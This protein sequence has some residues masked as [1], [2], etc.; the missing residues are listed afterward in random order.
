VIA[1]RVGGLPAAVQD[2]VDGILCEP[3][4]ASV[5]AAIERMA[6]DHTQL[7][8][9]VRAGALDHSFDRYCALVDDAVASRRG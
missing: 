2:G 5:A 4:A 1:T 8:A 7:A 9:G 3:D 6:V